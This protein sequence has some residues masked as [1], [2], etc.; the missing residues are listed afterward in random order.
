MA[1]DR[2]IVGSCDPHALMRPGLMQF[3]A[4]AGVTCQHGK[5]H[6]TCREVAMSR[7]YVAVRGSM[8]LIYGPR[9][10]PC[11]PDAMSFPGLTTEWIDNPRA[12]TYRQRG[13][14]D[15]F[16]YQ[17]IEHWVV[18]TRGHSTLCSRPLTA[19][20]IALDTLQHMARELIDFT[21]FAWMSEA[22]DWDD[23]Q[24]DITGGPLVYPVECMRFWLRLR[25]MDAIATLQSLSL[26]ITTGDRMQA[27]FSM[28]L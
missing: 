3:L 13:R 7:L 22:P 9:V 6:C 10:R 8:R 21:P 26:A 28:P 17:G 4:R 18:H 5:S 27:L 11:G 24:L 14:P 2:E 15:S 12:R 20:V 25:W 23:D 19:L 16:S 1:L